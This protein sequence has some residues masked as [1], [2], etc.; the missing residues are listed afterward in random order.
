MSEARARVGARVARLAL[1]SALAKGPGFL[2]PLVLATSFGA[3]RHTDEYFLAYAVMLFVGGGLGQALEAAVV[4]Y[5]ADALHAAPDAALVRILRYV[6]AATVAGAVAAALGLAAL[7][8]GIPLSGA[9]VGIPQA[10]LYFACLVPAV[11]AW[12]AAGVLAG[13][14]TAAGR[15]ERSAVGNGF[16]GAGALLGAA[17]A[18]MTGQLLFV[19]VGL[20]L[21]EVSRVLWLAGEWRRSA[22]HWRRSLDGASAP[23]LENFRGAA[24]AQVTA[25]AALAAAPLIERFV[26][27]AIAVAA[28]SRVEYAW[29]LVAVFT[30]VFDGGVAPWLLARWSQLRS[31]GGF[32]ARW[33]Q[34]VRPLGAA[35]A[36]AL[37]IA[38]G[39]SAG[40]GP[41][42]RTLFAHGAFTDAD[43]TVVA[44]LLRVYALGFAANMIAL[45]AERALLATGQNRLFLRLGWIRVGVRLAVVLAAMR[46]LGLYALPIGYAASEA[47]YLVAMLSTLRRATA[48]VLARA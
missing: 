1:L 36:L 7:V 23:P 32:T 3:G 9:S 46:P 47:V 13:S 10:L 43:V 37:L 38:L 15:L 21:G 25:Q 6:R 20:S 29:R 48:P 22:I 35:T 19:A 45:C 42:V 18:A 34:I 41:I 27:G 4:P 31:G 40:A 5:A 17:V 8:A 33:E 16:R 26:A 44:R 39:L 14:L 28:I 11:I 12:P 30:V 2:I 24:T